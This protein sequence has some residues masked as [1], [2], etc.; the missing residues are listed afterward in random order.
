MTSPQTEILFAPLEPAEHAVWN[1]LRPHTGRA[2][3]IR[4]DDLARATGLRERD[5][6]HALKKLIEK[7]GKRIGSTPT[8]PPG[9]FIIETDDEAWECCERYHRQALSILVREM[10]L[11]RIARRDLLGQLEIELAK[12]EG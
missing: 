1:A 12:E 9:Y 5:M 2:R 8:Y 4:K 11:R 10:R 3:A 7:H 6:R